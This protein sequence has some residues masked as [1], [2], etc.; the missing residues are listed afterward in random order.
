[1][2]YTLLANDIQAALDALKSV[3]GG[4]SPRRCHRIQVC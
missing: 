2:Q 3:K 4:P 1:V